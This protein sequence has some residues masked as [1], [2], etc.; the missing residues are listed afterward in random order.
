MDFCAPSGLPAS[1]SGSHIS[2]G[3]YG[4]LVG[5]CSGDSENVFHREGALAGEYNPENGVVHFRLETR[6][7]FSPGAGAVTSILSFE[8]NSVVNGNTASGVGNFDFSCSAEGEGLH[9]LGDQTTM[10]LNGTM[11]FQIVFSP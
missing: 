11:P 1:N 7:V 4:G 5:Q 8:G 2:I 10:Q 6:R 9:C 3:E